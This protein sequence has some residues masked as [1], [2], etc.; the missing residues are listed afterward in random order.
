MTNN[1]SYMF[2]CKKKNAIDGKTYRVYQIMPLPNQFGA[3]GLV[4]IMYCEQDKKFDANDLSQFEIIDEV[5]P[6]L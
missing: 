5:S 1:N 6:L 3:L 2:K 4:G